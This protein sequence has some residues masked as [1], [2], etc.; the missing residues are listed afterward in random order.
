MTSFKK[1]INR[2]SMS[3]Q[4]RLSRRAKLLGL[5]LV[6]CTL[7]V[8]LPAYG[9]TLFDFSGDTPKEGWRTNMWG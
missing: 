9:H 1:Q 8:P 6:A 3:S 2:E 7:A 5:V 4:A